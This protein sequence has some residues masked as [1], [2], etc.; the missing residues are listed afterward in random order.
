MLISP[1]REGGF[2]GPLGD[3]IHDTPQ[4]EHYNAFVLWTL[5]GLNTTCL[6]QG[7]SAFSKFSFDLMS[8]NFVEIYIKIS[9]FWETIE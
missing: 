6:L 7:P 1:C 2:H 9:N 4:Y 3:C 8:E 5:H